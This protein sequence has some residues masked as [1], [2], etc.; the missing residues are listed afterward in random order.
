MTHHEKGY[1]AEQ[2]EQLVEAHLG[3][4]IDTPL[5]SD[6]FDMSYDVLSF[7]FRKVVSEIDSRWRGPFLE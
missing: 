3:T 5:R 4:S 7:V 1:T 2:I 6:A